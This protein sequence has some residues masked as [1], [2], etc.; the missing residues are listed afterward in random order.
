[1]RILITHGTDSM[2]ETATFLGEHDV[3]NKT[4]VLVGSFVPL[5]QEKSDAFFNL[6]YA[7]RAAQTLPSGVW[8]AINV[9]VFAWNNVRKNKEKARFERVDQ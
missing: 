8:I 4:V 7:M 6:G 9:E 5:S 2:V 1:M 3:G